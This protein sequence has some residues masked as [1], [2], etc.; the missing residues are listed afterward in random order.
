MAKTTH[1]TIVSSPGFTHLVPITEFS[2]RLE[3]HHPNFH[4]TCIVPSLGPPSESS[5]AYLETLPSNIQTILLPPINKE[6]LPQGVHPA[7]LIQLTVTHS[8]P[9][10]HEVLKSRFSKDPLV[11]LVVDLFAFQALEFAKEFKALSYFYFPSSALVLSLLLH[12]LVL[13]GPTVGAKCSYQGSGVDSIRW[14]RSVSLLRW[15][16]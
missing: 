5:K 4:V 16:T 14:V 8:L 15:Y 2:K 10:I 9:A 13:I 6:Q 12:A 3:K 1:I 7:I 11:A